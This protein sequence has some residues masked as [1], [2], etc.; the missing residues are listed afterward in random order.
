MWHECRTQCL[1]QTRDGGASP[2]SDCSLDFLCCDCSDGGR[3]PL[4]AGLVCGP[5]RPWASSPDQR[6]F[7]EASKHGRG[8]PGPHPPLLAPWGSRAPSRLLSEPRR[9]ICNEAAANVCADARSPAAATVSRP[10]LPGGRSVGCPSP[11]QGG[12]RSCVRRKPSRT[13]LP[14][15][16]RLGWERRLF[17]ARGRG[18]HRR[19]LLGPVVHADP[20]EGSTS[21]APVPAPRAEP[22][23]HEGPGHLGHGHCSC[24]TS[25][26]GEGVSD[27][28]PGITRACSR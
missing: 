16:R 2:D 3:L 15:S 5:R 25:S 13:H 14:R 8:R 20:G 4:G 21:P 10:C 23:A 9:G 24:P 26:T 28:G 19:P 17:S 11:S 22:M 6:G 1:R 7:R 18:M 12:R 27:P